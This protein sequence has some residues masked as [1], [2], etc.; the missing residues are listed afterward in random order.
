ML[1]RAF[2]RWERSFRAD[3]RSDNYAVFR[4]HMNR[5]GLPD[6]PK[7]MVEGTIR[8]V[9]AILAYSSIDGQPSE[10]F[11]ERQKYN[12]SQATDACYALTFDLC[13]RAYARVLVDRELKSV[14]LADLLGH[15]WEDYEVAG[16]TRIWISNPD[17]TGLTSEELK[18]LEDAVTDDLLFDYSEDEVNFWFDASP[19]NSFLLVGDVSEERDTGSGDEPKG[20]TACLACGCDIEDGQRYFCVQRLRRLRGDLDFNEDENLDIMSSIQI[21]APCMTKAS[22]EAITFEEKPVPILNLEKEGV[23]KLARSL[24]SWRSTSGL[25]TKSEGSCHFCRKAISKG[26]TYTRIEIEE[27]VESGGV[28]ERQEVLAVLAVVCEE[29]AKKYM[30]WL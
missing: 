1:S 25:T 27:D 3:A 28:F 18:Q 24:G 2:H 16:F 29:C 6:E 7:L 13:G 8:V 4:D 30:I 15:P 5:L 9:E 23:R 21:C 14:D 11:L 17:W 12:P 10:L 20:L 26:E 19:D 22:T